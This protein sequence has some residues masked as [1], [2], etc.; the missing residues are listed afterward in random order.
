MTT[1]GGSALKAI[2]AL[3][4]AGASVEHVVTVVDREEGA[5]DAFAAAGITLHA[6]F[7]KGEFAA[8]GE[9]K[10]TTPGQATAKSGG[11]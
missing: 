10:S 8:E 7:R 5:T 3:R 1:T 2:A 9:T 11:A 4:E 6:L